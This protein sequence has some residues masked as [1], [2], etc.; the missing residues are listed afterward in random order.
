MLVKRAPVAIDLE[1]RQIAV[2]VD[3]LG[4]VS[5]TYHPEKNVIAH[6]TITIHEKYSSNFQFVQILC[7]KFESWQK[8]QSLHNNFKAF[9]TGIAIYNAVVNIMFIIPSFMVLLI[10]PKVLATYTKVK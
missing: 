3:I 1:T 2:P 4:E 9:E 7:V 10:L 5:Y 6:S 8:F